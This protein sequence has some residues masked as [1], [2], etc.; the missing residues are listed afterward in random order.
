MGRLKG[1]PVSDNLH[2]GEVGAAPKPKFSLV[3][4][5]FYE[6]LVSSIQI[7]ARPEL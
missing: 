4:G 3:Y 1:A 2:V 5:G 7:S 6:K